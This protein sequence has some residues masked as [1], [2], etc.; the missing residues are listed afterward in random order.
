MKL[1]KEQAKMVIEYFAKQAAEEAP[2]Q[3]TTWN[4]WDKHMWLTCYTVS[5]AVERLINIKDWA[6]LVNAALDSQRFDRDPEGYLHE[7]GWTDSSKE[8][9]HDTLDDVLSMHIDTAFNTSRAA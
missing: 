1:T 8:W 2:V 4:N 5:L 9:M 7:H 6:A 3:D